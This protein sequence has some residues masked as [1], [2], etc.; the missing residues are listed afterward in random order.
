MTAVGLPVEQALAIIA[1]TWSLSWL[2]DRLMTM[3]NIEG[4]MLAASFV[5]KYKDKKFFNF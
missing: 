3:V 1:P 2:E 4:D 5:E